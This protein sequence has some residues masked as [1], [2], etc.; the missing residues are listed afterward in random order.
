MGTVERV[1]RFGI[2]S[3]VGWAIDFA[4]FALLVHGGAS[5]LAA[6]LVGASLA[7]TW[8]FAA[9]VRRIFAYDGRF[10]FG[11]F[12]LYAAWQV[13][14]VAAASLAIDLLH[15]HAG[16]GPLLAK[17][18]VTPLTFAC[19]YLFMAWLTGPDRSRACDA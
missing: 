11:R 17:I 18:L 12:A 10:L 15:R 14:A 1:L 19:N 4:V 3:G 9:S 5:V 2:V 6:N 7:V 16:I 13:A 8:V